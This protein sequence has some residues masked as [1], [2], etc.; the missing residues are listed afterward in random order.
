MA[1]KN[2]LAHRH[3]RVT[4]T[5]FVTRIS[6]SE[7]RLRASAMVLRFRLA[8][9][10]AEIGLVKRYLERG[11]ETA[12]RQALDPLFPRP[13]SRSLPPTNPPPLLAR[14]QAHRKLRPENGFTFSAISQ[15]CPGQ[16]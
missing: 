6:T 7:P 8:V 9:I 11:C 13:L 15:I 16:P 1:E 4:L 5:A 14:R 10:F 3:L 2:K 12:W